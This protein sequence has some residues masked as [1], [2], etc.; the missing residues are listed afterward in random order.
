MSTV[1]SGKST[2]RG[3]L[4]NLPRVARLLEDRS[5]VILVNNRHVQVCRS[6]YQLATQV[7]GGYLE[8][9]ERREESDLHTN[10][11]KGKI[12]LFLAVF[13]RGNNVLLQLLSVSGN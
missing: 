13:D 8:L 4:L 7:S 2:C 6:L 9:C 5:V 11:Q 12:Q 10:A 3:A 1:R